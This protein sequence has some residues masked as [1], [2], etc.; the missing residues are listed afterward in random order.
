MAFWRTDFPHAIMRSLYALERGTYEHA[1]DMPAAAELAA[2]VRSRRQLAALVAWY[3]TGCRESDFDDDGALEIPAAL[4]RNDEEREIVASLQVEEIEAE[5]ARVAIRV[6]RTATTCAT[7][8]DAY[9][10]AAGCLERIQRRWP[11]L[12]ELPRAIESVY[13]L[14]RRYGAYRTPPRP[15]CRPRAHRQRRGVRRCSQ[16][17]RSPGREDDPEPLARRPA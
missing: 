1:I 8:Q 17:A 9:N 7:A 4:L 2:Q 6:A 11:D 15:L 16:R 12:D 3:A 10:F 13:R 14:A 5:A